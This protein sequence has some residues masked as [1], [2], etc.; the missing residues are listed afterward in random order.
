MADVFQ[1]SE[2]SRIMALIRGKN[3]KPEKIVRSIAHR[4]GYRFR[5]HRRDLP[6]TPDLVF[7]KL[8]KVVFVHGCFWHMHSC[9]KGHSTPATNVKFW[10]RKRQGN[11]RRDRCANAKLRRS[12]WQVLTIW[13]CQLRDRMRVAS[14]LAAFLSGEG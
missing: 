14:R 8:R 5:L 2:R 9:R 4:L 6:G 3:T 10:S 12:G 11:A 7:P 13:E 1:P